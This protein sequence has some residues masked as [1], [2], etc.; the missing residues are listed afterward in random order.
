MTNI[1]QNSLVKQDESR[2]SLAYKCGKL[3]LASLGT[4]IVPVILADRYGTKPGCD[5]GFYVMTAGFVIIGIAFIFC[6]LGIISIPAII[7]FAMYGT[8]RPLLDAFI[9]MSS[10][11]VEKLLFFSFFIPML[12]ALVSLPYL[13]LDG[14]NYS[15]AFFVFLIMWILCFLCFYLWMLNMFSKTYG[16]YVLIW[17]VNTVHTLISII[18][19]FS[20]N[21]K[22]S[23]IKAAVAIVAVVVF[24]MFFVF[25]LLFCCDPTTTEGVEEKKSCS[26]YGTNNS[27]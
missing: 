1:S 23:F 8:E 14:S 12:P 5:A 25:S 22:S 11:F 15:F 24:I 17:A 13:L 26:E 6:I 10:G 18:V 20:S 21:E 9:V 3:I 16:L 27:Y 7:L 4:A 2:H 19:V